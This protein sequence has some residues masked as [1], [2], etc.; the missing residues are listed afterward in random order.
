MSLAAHDHRRADDWAPLTMRGDRS[1]DYVFVVFGRTAAR[2]R[3][4]A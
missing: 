2:G 4:F 1:G 3:G